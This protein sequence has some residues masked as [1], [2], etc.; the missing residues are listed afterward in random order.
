MCACGRREIDTFAQYKYNL[1]AT[2]QPL[3]EDGSWIVDGQSVHDDDDGDNDEEEDGDGDGDEDD[4]ELDDDGN[5]LDKKRKSKKSA[6]VAM[7]NKR[8]KSAVSAPS[9]ASNPSATS[10]TSSGSSSAPP[11]LRRSSSVPLV[12]PLLSSSSPAAASTNMGSTITA[13]S[14]SSLPALKRKVSVAFAPFTATAPSSAV[15]VLSVKSK[16]NG[17]AVPPSLARAASHVAATV[18]TSREGSPPAGTSSFCIYWFG[19]MFCA[20]HVTPC[21]CVCLCVLDRIR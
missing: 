8:A 3:A 16:T 10:G 14:A 1:T 21:P 18:A 20:I 9:S 11:L 13:N 6:K 19:L 7:C 17:K 12:L 5:L 4:A 2:G 15:N